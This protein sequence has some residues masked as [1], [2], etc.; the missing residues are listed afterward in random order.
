[1]GLISFFK[2]IFSNDYTIDNSKVYFTPFGLS[3]VDES[4][5]KKEFRK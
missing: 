3:D 4:F 1:M 5:R 2:D